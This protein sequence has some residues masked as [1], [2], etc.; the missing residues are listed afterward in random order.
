M[1]AFMNAYLTKRISSP[2]SPLFPRTKTVPLLPF[3]TT[4]LKIPPH[5]TIL[6]PLPKSLFPLPPQ[7]E[8]FVPLLSPKTSFIHSYHR[9]PHSSMASFFRQKAYISSVSLQPS[10]TSSLWK[11]ESPEINPNLERTLMSLCIAMRSIQNIFI[12]LERKSSKSLI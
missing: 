5:K 10:I 8:T 6:L 1:K 4:F 12:N 9:K 2:T 3:Q 7:K 11:Q